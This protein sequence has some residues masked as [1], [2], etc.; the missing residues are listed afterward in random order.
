MNLKVIKKDS[1]HLSIKAEYL[2][3]KS[4]K[5]ILNLL[6]PLKKLF[7]IM[8]FHIKWQN[9]YWIISMFAQKNNYD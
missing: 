7:S 8:N 4:I 9:L 1:F 5:Y 6:F 3:C 2:S